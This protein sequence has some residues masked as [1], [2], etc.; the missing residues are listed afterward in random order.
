MVPKEKALRRL[1]S[2]SAVAALL[3]ACLWLGSARGE[4]PA[5]EAPPAEEHASS[6][7]PPGPPPLA[8]CL[9]PSITPAY[10]GYYVGGG[11]PFCRLGEPRHPQEGTWGWDWTGFC[12]HRK[13]DLLW[14]HGRRYQGGTGAYRTDGPRPLER[15]HEVGEEHH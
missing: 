11:C 1:L 2:G 12:F 3:A 9:Q 13:V 5:A 8:R 10:I 15:L 14:W 4:P 6:C 7:R